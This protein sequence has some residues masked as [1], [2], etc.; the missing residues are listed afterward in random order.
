VWDFCCDELEDPH[1][2]RDVADKVLNLLEAQGEI[3]MHAEFV[4][5]Q[6]KFVMEIIRPL[7]D[8]KLG[9][10]LNT[11]VYQNDISEYIRMQTSPS[12]KPTDHYYLKK[13]LENLVKTGQFNPVVSPFLWYKLELSPDDYDEVNRMLR[14]IGVIFSSTYLAEWQKD[15]DEQGPAEKSLPVVL[16]RLSNDP[17][18]Q[19]VNKVWPKVCPSGV[20]EMEM[21]I[22]LPGGCPP[23][24]AAHF[25]AALHQKG[26][27]TYGWLKGAIVVTSDNKEI[28]ASLVEKNDDADSTPFLQVIIRSST[29]LGKEEISILMEMMNFMTQER[30]QRFPGLFFNIFIP[31]PE[32]SRP[33]IEWDQNEGK[34]NTAGRLHFCEECRKHVKLTLFLD[35]AAAVPSDDKAPMREYEIFISAR[36]DGSQREQDARDLKDELVKIDVDAHMVEAAAGEDFGDKTHEYLYYM[37]TMI[38]F[39]F[40]DYGQKTKSKYSTY[41]ELKDAYAHDK[42]IL[43]IKRCAEWPPKPIDHDGGNKGDIQNTSVF[44][45]GVA[46]LDWSKNNW[47]PAECAKEVKEALQKRSKP[48][49]L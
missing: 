36:F 29:T 24:L 21:R 23:T 41:W 35:I 6:P 3:F 16:Y 26:R 4:F 45:P 43:P 31:C 25:A 20:K 10:R 5:V 34:K 17:D 38:A 46:Y 22:E 30:E 18:L 27:C 42:H 12:T 28:R 8:H 7:V 48:N 49:P 33:T 32:C 19:L 44:K 11:Q 37:K 40:E 9:S 1:I 13:A 14:E 39:C 47:N 2:I 15:D